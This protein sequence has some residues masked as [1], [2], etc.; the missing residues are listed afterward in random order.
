MSEQLPAFGKKAFLL[1]SVMIV[2][3]FS[4]YVGQV[5]S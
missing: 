5:Q 3:N 2:L 4:P 1:A